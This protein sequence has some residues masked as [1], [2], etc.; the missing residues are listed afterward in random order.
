[1]PPSTISGGRGRLQGSYAKKL[2]DLEF[3]RLKAAG[4]LTSEE[5]RSIQ[6]LLLVAADALARAIGLERLPR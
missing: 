1:M 2:P 5:I 4:C 6:M 3:L